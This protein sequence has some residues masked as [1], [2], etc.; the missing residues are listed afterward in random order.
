[1]WRAPSPQG[2]NGKP[3]PVKA[4]SM[5]GREGETCNIKMQEVDK[6][7]LIRG[8]KGECRE[9]GGEGGG[10]GGP[11]W[12]GGGGRHW[13]PVAGTRL[14]LSVGLVASQERFILLRGAVGGRIKGAWVKSAVEFTI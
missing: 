4:Q 2:G 10:G 1:M 7:R 8:R 14:F 3:F 9:E 6:S 13:D 12:G 5:R 11:G